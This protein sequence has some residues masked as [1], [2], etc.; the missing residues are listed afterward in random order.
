MACELRRF[1]EQQISG[2]VLT[3]NACVAWSRM[4]ALATTDSSEVARATILDQA[5][6]AF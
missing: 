5:M 1:R 4:V 2:A 6:Q 3:Q